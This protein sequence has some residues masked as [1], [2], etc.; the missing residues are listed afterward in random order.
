MIIGMPIQ[1]MIKMMQIFLGQFC[2]ISNAAP[3]WP[4]IHRPPPLSLRPFSSE[5]GR[6]QKYALLSMIQA[7]LLG[8]YFL[9]NFFGY[10][11]HIRILVVYG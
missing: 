5:K 11:R 6:N 7:C 4:H 1:V 3:S 8:P 9:F 2:F 10:V